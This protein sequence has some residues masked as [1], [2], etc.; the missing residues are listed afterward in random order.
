MMMTTPPE[1]PSYKQTLQLPET[2]FPMRAGAATR[3]PELQRLW[4]EQGVY[5]QLTTER[6]H[7]P[8]FVLHDGPPYLSSDK[9]H[10]GHALNKILKDIVL[11]FKTQQGHYVPYVPGYDGHGL[12]IEAAVEKKI[13]GGRKAVTPL[14][15]RQQ[16]RAFAH[17]NVAG[18]E[19]NFK[20]MGILGNWTQPYVTIDADFEATQIELFADMV[21]KGYVYKGL[22]PVHWCPVSESAMA[23]AEIDYADH[24]SHSIYVRFPLPSLNKRYGAALPAELAEALIDASFV[25]WTTTPWTLPSN[26]ALAVHPTVEYTV[27]TSPQFG[28]LIVATA[29]V[30]SI[31]KL[32]CFEDTPLQPTHLTFKGEVLE[33]L[34]AR[35]PFINRASLVLTADYV[36][37]D[38]GTGVVHTAP[39]HGPDDFKSVQQLNRTVLKASPLPILSP[40]DT[41]GKYT[42]E[43]DVPEQLRGLF[44][45]K[46]NWLVLEILK[47][48]TALL[49]NS[50]FT[51]SYPHSWRS[52]APVIFRATE[53]WFINVDAFRHEALEAIK[54]VQ[55]VPE[56]G[57]TRIATMVANRAEWCISR[58]RVWGVPIPAFYCTN[59]GKQH[60][61]KE[62]VG[63]VA[64]VFRK[65]SSD[66]WV[67]Y[68]A[69]ELLDG[70]LTCDCGSTDF[71]KEED[72]M[73]VWFDS[74]VT[75]TAV[76]KA[77]EE[78]LGPLPVEL[79]LEGS[80]QH[81]GWF[82]SSL[83]TSVMLTGKA[84]YKAVLTHGFVLDE[85]G[86]KMSKSL[87]NVIDPNS[88]MKD[89][90]ADVLRLWVA[91]VDYSS[92]VRIGQNA[93]KQLSDV[94]RKIRNTA[95][96][97]LG[98]LHG[99]NPAT[100]L[101]PYEQ[102]SALDTYIL[103]RVAT[104]CQQ[105]QEA[106]NHYEFHKFYQLVQ[107]LCV[108]DLSSLYFDVVKDV[109]YCNALNDTTRLGVQTTLYHILSMLCRVIVPVLPHLAEDIWQHWPEAQRPSFGLSQ[110]PSSILLAPW[111]TAPT[112]WTLAPEALASFEQ[113][114]ALRDDVNQALETARSQ[115]HIGSA[116]EAALVL[117]LPDP[118]VA[119]AEL[120]E[121]L[122]LVSQ[123]QVVA[124]GEQP[125]HVEAVLVERACLNDTGKVQVVRASGAKC[126][127][128]WKY[129]PT[130][131][132]FSNH[133]TLCDR[134]HT[135][136]S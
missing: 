36:T 60:I 109:L 87:G 95:R 122:S 70:R 130:V 119:D 131:G 44:Y 23:E 28:K 126:E 136:V 77:R 101:V 56:R 71:R 92:D 3:E 67:K 64:D 79:Y 98:N 16:C 110:A 90:G 42:H 34:E 31:A 120:L 114:L 83:L 96:F 125:S 22:K 5:T 43:A 132:S 7:L 45:E 29:L 66:A 127:R 78:E 91:S 107:H 27:V 2:T 32:P 65:E 86:R 9:I 121:L 18:Q 25:I 103:H 37:T 134:C 63:W 111:A 38:A 10:I 133:P 104:V 15:L 55:W 4:E 105:L 1:A 49:H 46:A 75:H 21:E 74:G 13:K 52:H 20:R 88:V 94:Y 89:V 85:N 11:R 113:L 129:K 24:E 76:V 128:C 135:A 33:G 57:E 50:I 62:I 72:V 47:Q 80:D 54:G 123:V 81:R 59:C 19:A 6:K 82:Q 51:H 35:H 48:H 99:F 116:L 118:T 61:N 117:H 108:V 12:P 14:E 69:N 40:I 84:P 17:S 112:E 97:A 53:Q 93:I 58:Q 41:Q 39:G 73:D 124:M 115:Q 106:F 68:T 100:Q 26:V 102:L 30:E 8:K